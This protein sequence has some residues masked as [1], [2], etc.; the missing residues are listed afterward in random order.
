VGA[1]VVLESLLPTE[2]VRKLEAE[3]QALPGNSWEVPGVLSGK[4]WWKTME[5]SPRKL[6]RKKTI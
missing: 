4:N 6:E 3:A 5:K 1:E 2:W